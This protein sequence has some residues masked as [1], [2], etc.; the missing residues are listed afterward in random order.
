MTS[1]SPTL[2]V[3][4]R[5]LRREQNREAVIDAL[6]ELYEEGQYEPGANVIAERAGLSPRSLFRYFDDIDDLNSAAIDRQLEAARPLLD[7]GIRD[8]DS[9]VV[10]IER[11]VEARVRLFETIAPAARAARVCAPRHGIV[12]A[13]I[14]ESRSYLRHQLQRVFA[15]EL[16]ASGGALLPAIDALCAFEAYDLLRH[17]QRLSRGRTTAALVA[18]L[19]AML[20]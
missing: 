17:D 7:P 4:G 15:R 18:A 9:T 13:Q 2:D 12:A 3:D 19:T 8:D 10:K 5:R 6:V 11:V 20:A 14:R 16:R 1:T